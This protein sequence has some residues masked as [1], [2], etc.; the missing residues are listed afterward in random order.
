[1]DKEFEEFFQYLEE[2]ISTE[3]NEGKMEMKKILK[4]LKYLLWKQQLKSYAKIILILLSIC[5][6]IIYI[7]SLNWLF[8]GVGRIF[9]IKFLPL[10]NWRY[11]GKSKCL[12]EKPQVQ[13]HG[14]NNEVDELGSR[15]C[16]VC[17]N[18]DQI[19]VVKETKYSNIHDKYLIRGLPVIVSD[20]IKAPNQS[21]KNNNN[22]SLSSFI[23]NIFTNMSDMITAKAC[24]LETNLMMSKYA[25]LDKVLE[26]ILKTVEQNDKFFVSFR[27]C[28]FKAVKASRLIMK[29]PYFYPTNL[30]APYTTWLLMSQHYEN[31]QNEL[32]VYGLV[33]VTQMKG[34]LKVSLKI[35]KTCES[36]CK[37]L[38]VKLFAGESLV[39]F[40]HLW[41]FSYEY[42]ADN[43]SYSITYITETNLY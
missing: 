27:N 16:R 25:T 22:E 32:E 24:N 15:D 5:F 1:M 9:L 33:I 37:D 12:I 3:S 6:A 26:V 23:D 38:N 39:F 29:K 20:T 8:C 10:W 42:V 4:P 31:Y 28:K 35:K 36:L 17:E 19:D 21:D 40:A 13:L 43:D 11:L 34:S 7:D 2:K 18:F 30:Q 41:T 14:N